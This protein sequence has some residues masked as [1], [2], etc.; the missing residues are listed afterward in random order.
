MLDKQYYINKYINND[1]IPDSIDSNPD[2]IDEFKSSFSSEEYIK[3][4]S[5]IKSKYRNDE[6]VEYDLNNHNVKFSRSGEYVGG[7]VILGGD[8]TENGQT[9]MPKKEWNR[10]N[11][12]YKKSSLKK[13]QPL[14]KE[15]HLFQ[16]VVDGKFIIGNYNEFKESDVIAPARF[17]FD[18][19]DLEL[20]NNGITSSGVNGENKINFSS[21]GK[22]LLYDKES[23]S[24]RYVY[25]KTKE[26]FNAM[27]KFKEKHPN[28]KY[29]MMDNGRYNYYKRNDSGLTKDDYK[30]YY[31]GDWARTNKSGFNLVLD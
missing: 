9:A 15:T 13:K 4:K 22:I 8:F 27:N 14:N 25:G 30:L 31:S 17:V 19:D 10:R 12:Y 2:I 28:A 11:T 18:W 6:Y 29:M 26:I 7:K 16:G 20:K 24:Y 23:N 21:K 1:Y 3:S 5:G